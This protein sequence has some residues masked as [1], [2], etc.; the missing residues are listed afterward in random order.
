[1]EQWNLFRCF[2]IIGLKPDAIRWA[3]PMALGK[4]EYWNDRLYP[5]LFVTNF[6]PIKEASYFTSKY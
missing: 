6:Y 3:E 4:P 5:K 1:M 2:L